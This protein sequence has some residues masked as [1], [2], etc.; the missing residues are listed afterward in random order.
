MVHEILLPSSDE[1][2]LYGEEYHAAGLKTLPHDQA[3]ISKSLQIRCPHFF[4]INGILGYWK[5]NK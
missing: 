5:E 3:F 4:P 1:K 2:T